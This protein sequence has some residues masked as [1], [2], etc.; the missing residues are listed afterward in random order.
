[1]EDIQYNTH[2]CWFYVSFW[3]LS[4]QHERCYVFENCFC[5]FITKRQ[6]AVNCRSTCQRLNQTLVVWLCWVQELRSLV[7]LFSVIC[8]ITGYNW[9]KWI[10]DID[11]FL[12][13]E[14]STV[15]GWWEELV[16]FSN[17]G[18]SGP[19]LYFMVASAQWCGKA[20]FYQLCER[21]M[22]VSLPN[23]SSV[24]SWW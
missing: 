13:K 10:L 20:G 24:T 23:F 1:M 11:V 22:L 6:L 4:L 2:G 14:L 9:I 21:Q 16:Q 12:L 5:W 15:N 18:F 8:R 3:C 17:W 19:S 7:L